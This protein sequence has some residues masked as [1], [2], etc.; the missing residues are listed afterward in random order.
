MARLEK[1]LGP[2]LHMG[3]EYGKLRVM[4]MVVAIVRFDQSEDMARIW[5]G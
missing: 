1:C 3:L 2:G 4:V 5:Q